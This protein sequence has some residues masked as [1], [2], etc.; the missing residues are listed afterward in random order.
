MN[1]AVYG[2]TME[3]VSYMDTDSFIY[4]IPMNREEWDS[5]V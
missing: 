4:D 2:K 5:S 3:N 1:N